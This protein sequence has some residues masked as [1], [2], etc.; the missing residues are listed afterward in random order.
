MTSK[1]THSIRIT[2]LI[3]IIAAIYLFIT[4]RLI[5][6]QQNPLGLSDFGQQQHQQE[7]LSEALGRFDDPD[8]A[9]QF[10]ILQRAPENASHLDPTL[11]D[12][13]FTTIQTL[14]QLNVTTDQISNGR[15]PTADDPWTDVGPNNIGGRTRAL[16]IDPQNPANLYAGGVAGGIWRSTNGGATWSFTDDYM[17]NMAI[18]TMAFDPTDSTILYAGTGEDFFNLGGIRGSGIFSSTDAGISWN[19]LP[20][21]AGND[22]FYYVSDIVVSPNNPKH[23]YAA[24][25]TGIWRSTDGG[26]FWTDV[27]THSGDSSYCVELAIRTDTVTQDT[28]LASC[29]NHGQGGDAAV[30][31]STDS[32]QTWQQV[33]TEP[34][35]SRTSLAIAPSD[36]DTMYA[37]AS[38]Y[39]DTISWT[40][41]LHALFRST[42]GGATWEPRVRNSDNTAKINKLQLTNPLFAD[43]STCY[44]LTDQYY[45]QGYYDNVIA[46]DPTDPN[47]VWTGGIDIMKSTDG[48]QNWAM[49]SQWWWQ[50]G[51]IYLHADIHALVFHPGYD[52]GTTN[53]T[54]YV[55]SDGGIGRTDSANGNG[56]TNLCNPY[57]ATIS[58]TPLNN[59]YNVTQFYHGAVYPNGQTFFGGTQDN[60]TNRGNISDPNWD[61]IIGGDGGYVAVNPITPT[62]VYAEEQNRR[63]LKST[64][65]GTTFISAVSGITESTAN[66]LFIT[67]FIMDPNDPDRLWIGGHTLWRTDN[68]ATSWTQASP[69]DLTNGNFISAWAVQP[70]NSDLVLVADSGGNIY[71]Q[72][73]ATTANSTTS[74]INATEA[75][76]DIDSLGGFVSSLTFD[77][78]TTSTVYATVSQFGVPHLWRSTDSGITW[79]P[80]GGTLPDIPF[81][82]VVI[83]HGNSNRLYVGTDRGILTTNNGGRNWYYAQGFPH[84]PTEWLQF[85]TDNGIEYLY[86]FTHGRG[87][88]RAPTP[89]S[90]I[91][92]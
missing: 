47:T 56:S 51:P 29:G 60:G 33:L 83:P 5:Q 41:G 44:A 81:H 71:R 3:T 74:W 20:S 79:A 36:Q 25:R 90:L 58:W 65:G 53:A 62:I 40:H 73:N 19:Q 85:A 88:L 17:E 76:S 46:V 59:G 80:F 32:G 87:T 23:L 26:T 21:T 72:T 7:F 35:M 91:H 68:G 38:T 18:T 34:Y 49:V 63:F 13:G 92:I 9:A 1:T 10:Y 6:D 67:P 52:G 82:H 15:A 30:Y 16:L 27:L 75:Q 45:S 55:G 2:L 8:A 57:D 66:Y 24:T 37:L 61:Q 70:G 11:Y 89:L 12:T 22:D 86:A 28:L 43:Y 39:D 4:Y 50:D 31:R 48:G 14:P 42:D 64:D 69:T 84:V 78:N 54:L 77:P